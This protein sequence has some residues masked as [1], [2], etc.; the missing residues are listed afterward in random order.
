MASDN[1]KIAMLTAF[2]L[3]TLAS[4]GALWQR[5]AAIDIDESYSKLVP[6]ME[7]VLADHGTEFHQI[8][9]DVQTLRGV[10]IEVTDDR[11]RGKD[12]AA[13]RRILDLELQR[14]EERLEA[15]CP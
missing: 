12:W 4:N 14:L 7:Q 1:Q 15:D 11:F 9:N 5:V 2:V 10:M 3:A 6:Q 8:R 13:Q